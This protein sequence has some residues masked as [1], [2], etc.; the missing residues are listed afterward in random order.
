MLLSPV[1]RIVIEV[2]GKQHYSDGDLSSPSK[3]SE[4]VKS[5]RELRLLGY[6]VYRFGGTELSEAACGSTVTTFFTNLFRKHNVRRPD[7]SA[8][9]EGPS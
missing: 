8:A 5:D 3:Y 1:E 4:M 6:E 7:G 9:H 2:D